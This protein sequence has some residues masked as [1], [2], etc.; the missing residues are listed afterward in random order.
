[1]VTST[2]K[3][4][5]QGGT[6]TLRRNFQQGCMLQG[7]YT[8]GKAMNDA[9]IAVGTTAF[10]DAADIG[11]EWA[12]AGYDVSAQARARRRV[13]DAVL[14]EQ[15]R[16]T[17]DAARRLAARRIGDLADRQPDQR[18]QRRRVPARRLQRRRQ[19]R[20]SA[21]RADRRTSR[22]SGWSQDEYLTGIFKA[23]DFPV[24][25]PGTN[26]NLV[27]Q[28]LSRTRLRRRQPVVVEEVHA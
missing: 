3:S 9:D 12:L 17:Q 1:M 2:S 24:P 6:V 27:A 14:Q 10:Q 19:R 16:L 15:H 13:G 22:P 20:R 25:A 5:Y 11:A 26:G 21:E 4:D 28:R 23:T 7:A 8:F 18:H